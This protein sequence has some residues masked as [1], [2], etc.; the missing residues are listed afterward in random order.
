M[1]KINSLLQKV[2]LFE[3]LAVYGDRKSFLEAL[4]QQ[5]WGDVS[6]QEGFAPESPGIPAPPPEAPPV[7]VDS[8]PKAKPAPTA[9][10][11]SPAALY[12]IQNFMNKDMLNELPP[13]TPDGKWGPETAGRVLAWG[14]K[15]APK[16][17]MQQLLAVLKV[18]AMGAGVEQQLQ[19][20]PNL[21][22]EK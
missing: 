11:V 14:K 18:K 5:T 6:R 9:Q 10:P 7:P 13:I 4:S 19:P 17:N 20:G 2:E 21:L 16:L 3:R 8:L 22:A 12:T 15:N 1:K